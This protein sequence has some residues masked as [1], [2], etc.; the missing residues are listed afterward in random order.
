VALAH[1]PRHP[2]YDSY[3]RGL[4]NP[5]SESGVVRVLGCCNKKDCHETEAEMR[6]GE[7]WAKIGKATVIHKTPPPRFGDRTAGHYDPSQDE[8]IW[9]LTEWKK[10]PPKAVIERTANPT[11]SPVICH[12]AQMEIWCF[13]PDNQF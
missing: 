6:N 13:V 9:E 2:E 5:N 4:K 12:S 7:W 1:D 8:V 3:Y 11:G 10:V